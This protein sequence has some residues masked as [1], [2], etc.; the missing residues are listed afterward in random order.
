MNIYSIIKDETEKFVD[1]L[2][3]KSEWKIGDIYKIIVCGESADLP[4]FLNHIGQNIDIDMVQAN[5]WTNIFNVN[6]YLPPINFH[7]S[8]NYSRVVGLAMPYMKIKK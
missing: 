1:Y 7:N 8:L 3:T 5:V 4:G 6:D 2:R